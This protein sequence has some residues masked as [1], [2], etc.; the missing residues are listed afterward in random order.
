MES[1]DWIDEENLIGIS[2]LEDYDNQ[3]FPVYPMSEHFTSPWETE[4]W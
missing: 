2:I 4:E 1:V 3:T